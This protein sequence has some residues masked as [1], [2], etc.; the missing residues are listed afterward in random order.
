MARTTR[1]VHGEKMIRVTVY[2]FTDNLAPKGRV[3]RKHA[4]G[5]GTVYVPRNRVHGITPSKS[6]PWGDTAGLNELPQVI[7]SVL[8]RKGVTIH[9]DH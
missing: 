6:E 1:A 9:R 4:W 8:R 7:R 3:R 5:S 2:F